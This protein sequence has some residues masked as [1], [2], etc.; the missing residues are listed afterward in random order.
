MNK[1]NKRLRREAHAMA[2]A[3]YRVGAIDF[4]TMREFDA[5]CLSEVHDLTASKIKAIRIKA[6]VSQSVFAKIINVSLAAIK[7]WERGERK[8][9]GPA[10]KLLNLAESRGLDAII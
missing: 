3:L 2:T 10:L 6:K 4:T 5:L 1:T 9:S 7:Q 8:P